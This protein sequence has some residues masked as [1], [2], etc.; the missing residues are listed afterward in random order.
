MLGH[1]RALLVIQVPDT[2]RVEQHTLF[3]EDPEFS[4]GC[5]TNLSEDL[6]QLSCGAYIIDAGFYRDRYQV[7]LVRGGDWEHPVRQ[8]DCQHRREVVS[9][10]EEWLRDEAFIA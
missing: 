9:I 6:V 4:D 5:C 1:M 8:C 3:D 2:W 7:V 10:I